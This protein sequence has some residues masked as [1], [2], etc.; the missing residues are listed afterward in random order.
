VQ[1]LTE[2]MQRQT[3]AI[4]PSMLAENPLFDPLRERDDFKA[5]LAKV[6]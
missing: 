4:S 6:D 5:L 1:T 2:L 3:D